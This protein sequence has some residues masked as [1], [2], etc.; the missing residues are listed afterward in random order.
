MKMGKRFARHKRSAALLLAAI[1][2]I[3]NVP[4]VSRAETMTERELKADIVVDLDKAL[5]AVYK[6]E[7]MGIE[8][9]NISDSVLMDIEVNGEIIAYRGKSGSL[10]YLVTN[11]KKL[12]SQRPM[13]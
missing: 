3:L 10:V 11:W 9:E 8:V 13:K 4:M 2:T 1:L 12:K 5:K 6:A 7:G